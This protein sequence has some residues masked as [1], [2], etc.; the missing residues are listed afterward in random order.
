VKRVDL[1]PAGSAARTSRSAGF[2]R[3]LSTASTAATAVT[4]PASTRLDTRQ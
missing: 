2:G 3:R 1:Q 4:T